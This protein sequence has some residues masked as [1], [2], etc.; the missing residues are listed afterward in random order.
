MDDF[1]TIIA[2]SCGSVMIFGSFL[3]FFA[4][5]RYLRY[6]EII[7][8]AE[9][10]LVHP[11]HATNGKGTLRW[12]IVITGLGVALCMGLYPLGWI[13]SN[14]MFPLNFGPW[15]LVG[16][17]PTFFGLSLLAI[18]YFTKLEKNSVGNSQHPPM[19]PNT[20]SSHGEEQ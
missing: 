5:M 11:Q 1:F 10:G 15:M 16:L 13:I 18:Y 8:L 7:I 2:I 17:I 20:E 12:G 19:T 9:K 3:A 6:R 14:G 4:F